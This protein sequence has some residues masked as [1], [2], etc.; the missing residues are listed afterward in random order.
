MI[1]CGDKEMTN[2]L[3]ALA[4]F[5]KDQGSS[6]NTQPSLNSSSMESNVLTG[7]QA[8]MCYTHIHSGKQLIP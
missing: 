4:A 5:V 3:R 1:N 8:G 6:P 7:F 2:L